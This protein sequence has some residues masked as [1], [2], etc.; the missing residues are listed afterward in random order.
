MA[1]NKTFYLKFRENGAVGVETLFNSAGE[2][3]K[4]PLE[5][6][7]HLIAAYKSIPGSF[8]ANVDSG[9]TLFS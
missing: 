6:V 4:R 2:E 7:G 3:Q 8:L 9:L 1:E 5:T